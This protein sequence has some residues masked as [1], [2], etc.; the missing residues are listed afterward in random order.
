MERVGGRTRD[1]RTIDDQP[2]GISTRIGQNQAI[3]GYFYLAIGGDVSGSVPV[4]CDE[5]IQCVPIEHDSLRSSIDENVATGNG[6]V[7]V[8]GQVHVYG[9]VH[10]NIRYIL[11]LFIAPRLQ[12]DD[13]HEE[14]K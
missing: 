3:R 5:L 13:R 14:T 9:E 1:Y 4:Q 8:R 7:D 11:L 6:Q 2:F 12:A 10:R